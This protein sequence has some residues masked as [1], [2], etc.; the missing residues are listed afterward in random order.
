MSCKPVRYIKENGK[1]VES[2]YWNYLF[3]KYQ[4]EDIAD[5]Y[6]K[7]GVILYT[8]TGYKKGSYNAFNEKDAWDKFNWLSKIADGVSKPYRISLG[9]EAM[10]VINIAKPKKFIS[11]PSFNRDIKY[12]NG[13]RALMEQEEGLDLKY[14]VNHIEMIEDIKKDLSEEN[15]LE[16]LDL[17]SNNIDEVVKSVKNAKAKIII[18]KTKQGNKNVK[19]VYTTTKGNTYN[20]KTNTITIDILEAKALSTLNN[21]SVR[22]TLDI[23]IAHE[24]IHAGLD[25][26]SKTHPEI[27]AK[28][29]KLHAEYIEADKKN[30]FIDK[31]RA[32]YRTETGETYQHSYEEFIADIANPY[33]GAY[34]KSINTSL[35]DKIANAIKEAINTIFGTNY[36]LDTVYDRV[37]ELLF[38]P[39]M[40]IENQAAI[41]AGLNLE[42]DIY[43]AI[44]SDNTYSGTVDKIKD[45]LKTQ[46]AVY[47][48]RKN[49]QKLV[50]DIE[51]LEKIINESASELESINY[52]IDEANTWTANAAT[53]FSTL[54]TK[55]NKGIDKL[56]EKE[57]RDA[58]E[59]IHELKEFASAYTILDD[60]ENEYYNSFD[61]IDESEQSKKLT[62]AIKFRNKIFSQYKKYGNDLIAEWIFKQAEQ[63]NANFI[64]QGKPEKVLTKN[65]IKEQLIMASGD[66]SVFEKLFGAAI[67]S[68]DPIL[69]LV[70]K[71]IKD[72]ME[73]TRIKDL[74]IQNELVG[75]YEAQSGNKTNVA[76]FNAQF[77]DQIDN[78]EVTGT[79]ADGKDIWGYV[80]RDTIVTEYNTSEFDK[81]KREFFAKLGPKP[82]NEKAI[83]E[84]SKKI[85]AWFN[86]NTKVIA[87]PT[88][89]IEKKKAELS[90]SNFNRWLKANT[91]EVIDTYYNDGGVK[92][93]YID[94]SKI[95]SLEN[96][97]IYLYSG[98]FIQPADN[99]KN[100]RYL[101]LK[102]NPYYI[103]LL[104]TYTDAN[105]QLLPSKQLKHGIIPQLRKEGLDAAIE[106][107]KLSTL[108]KNK[109]KESVTIQANDESRYG[110]K[111]LSG[112]DYRQ[113]PV[114][115]TTLIDSEELSH[116]LL[117]SILQF[118]AMSN[119]F[120]ALDSIRPQIEVIQD[121]NKDRQIADTN[122]RGIQL[123]N[124]VTG[125]TDIKTS[126]KLLNDRLQAFIDMVYY[127]E[128]TIAS[129]VDIFGKKISVDKLAGKFQGYS[130]LVSMAV[131]FTSAVSNATYGNFQ[132]FNESAGGRYYSKA[133]WLKAFAEYQKNLPKMAASL[134]AKV[135]NTKIT[136]LMDIYDAIQGEYKDN[137]GKNISGNTAKRL[138]TTD[139]LFFLQHGTEHQIQGT[140]MMAI[141]NAVKVK[142]ATGNEIS[143]YDA[144]D[145]NAKIKPGIV[146]TET[147]RKEITNRIHA[148]NKKLHGNYNSFDAPTLQ[149]F[150]YG[151]LMMMFR[152]HIY[153][154]IT[155]RWASEQIDYELGDTT[156]GYYRTF[157][158]AISDGWKNY[159]MNVLLY[160]KN[161][162]PEQKEAMRKLITDLA[163]LTASFLL[164]GAFGGDDDD[165]EKDTWAQS[166]IELQ[167][168]RFQ[169]DVNLY[170]F[171]T[172]DFTRIIKNPTIAMGTGEKVV[173]FLD[174]FLATYDP[175]KLY[176][177][178]KTGIHEKGDNKSWAKFKNLVPVVAKIE[179]TLEPKQQLTIYQK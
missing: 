98:E 4:N 86:A 178:R 131:N 17:K 104:K 85:S 174:Q 30:P 93:D 124:A 11:A 34:L 15:I 73:D 89:L 28:L 129:T 165:K 82:D 137:Y 68:Q 45:V 58:L 123:L 172:S 132:A 113:I 176:Y 2:K 12:Y 135:A 5:N 152:K 66:M 139:S 110:I 112:E 88:K 16:E 177:K 109:L 102:S 32:G 36:K 105:N 42:G 23:L 51:A 175:D 41:D 50:S 78:Y 35:F 140:G 151:K 179:Q 161:S 157:G 67:T 97:M 27:S 116:D 33:F 138:F 171:V 100:Q 72:V 150:W 127:G 9:D 94:S 108:A 87:N 46:K 148:I 69:A 164:A 64:K 149:R 57:Q 170:F 101:G 114:Y 145:D 142:D 79:D 168:R 19:V 14:G 52:F 81:N 24:F 26:A 141:L 122:S 47:R 21:V 143:L 48:K 107:Q 3:D 1:K 130:T 96:G 63:A 103:K 169:S 62:N 133:D 13:D 43:G 74:E 84:W 71:G 92:S 53:K 76:K 159:K 128:S 134:N 25:L 10:W 39:D 31:L 40:F 126:S 77:M 167:A 54:Q 111:R 95:Y 29:K 90:P 55:L 160:Y 37:T 61:N 121:I 119:N 20:P 118:S 7:A 99:Y 91:K 158:K 49:S 60:I 125:K 136:K 56:T 146:F 18:N 38:N 144:Y 59:L 80:K 156:E 65:A 83:K 155:R 117:E 162:T 22:E 44:P 153:G 147:Q 75:L 70:A 8:N 6:Y 115:F 166:M 163:F 106:G 154:G 173:S 120:E